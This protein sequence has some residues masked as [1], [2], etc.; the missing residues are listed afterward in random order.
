MGKYDGLIRY[1]KLIRD[2]IPEIIESNGAKCKLHVADD[3]EYW[4]KLRTKVSEEV[5]EF[6]DESCIEELADVVEVI[7][8]IADFKFGGREKLEE[9]RKEKALKRGGFVKKLVLDETDSN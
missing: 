5:G 8:A 4:D 3:D 7:Y 9:A 6:L 2:K 1:D